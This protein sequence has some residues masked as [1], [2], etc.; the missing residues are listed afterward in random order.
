[1][2]KNILIF[3]LVI[4][5]IQGH[6]YASPQKTI[7]GREISLEKVSFIIQEGW[8][9]NIA[10]NLFF[11]SV[12]VK[13]KSQDSWIEASDD[14]GDIGF[15]IYYNDEDNNLYVKGSGESIKED[16]TFNG[17]IYR[18]H[19]KTKY[20]YIGKAKIENGIL[21][22]LF[23]EGTRV[24]Y[25]KRMLNFLTHFFNPLDYDYLYSVYINIPG[26]LK[27]NF[28]VYFVYVDDKLTQI[29]ADLLK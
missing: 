19:A 25:K 10:P 12:N 17:K 2:N 15:M 11:T 29:K 24:T 5:V 22:P 9:T 3:L 28:E 13:I 26:V 16:L 27:P 21:K 23:L 18:A 8:G 1:M 6:I 14:N 20:Y 7:K 4:L